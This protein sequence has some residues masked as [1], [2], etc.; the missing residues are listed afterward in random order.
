MKPGIVSLAIAFNLLLAA[1]TFGQTPHKPA[2]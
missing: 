1:I 2:A